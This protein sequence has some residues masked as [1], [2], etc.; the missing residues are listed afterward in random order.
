MSSLTSNSVLR[1]VR[2]VTL[3]ATLVQV[4]GRVVLEL[5]SVK[6]KAVS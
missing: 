5:P 4:L 6:L 2:S 3:K 1:K